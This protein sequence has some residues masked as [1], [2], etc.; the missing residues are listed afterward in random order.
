MASISRSVRRDAFSGVWSEGTAVAEG[1]RGG[2]CGGDCGWIEEEL[3]VWHGDYDTSDCDE[4]VGFWYCDGDVV[5]AGFGVIGAG[6]LEDVAVAQ[7]RND[8]LQVVL[9]VGLRCCQNGSAVGAA[10][11]AEEIFGRGFAG[12][13]ESKAACFRGWQACEGVVELVGVLESKDG[14]ASVEEDLHGV[15]PFGGACCVDA[16]GDDEEDAA[17]GVVRD[18]LGDANDGVP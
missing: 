17:A 9:H 18:A 4:G 5:Q 7:H 8:V 14:D 2:G 16:I 1:C 6:K 11:F 13:L 12:G 3:C 10:K 15:R